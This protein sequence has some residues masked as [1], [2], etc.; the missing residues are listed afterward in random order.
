V[1]VTL[2]VD[3]ARAVRRAID[4]YRNWYKRAN[5]KGSFEVEIAELEA[6]EM[7]IQMAQ[8]KEWVDEEYEEERE[9]SREA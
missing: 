7:A 6:A 5:D 9:E 1:I 2:S 8:S 3:Q 4:R